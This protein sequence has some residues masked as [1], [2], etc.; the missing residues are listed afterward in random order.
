MASIAIV[1]EHYDAA[2]ERL[3]ALGADVVP[4]ELPAPSED[5]RDGTGT[6]IS[7]EA[8]YHHGN[9]YEAPSNRVDQDVKPRIL[10]GKG[11]SA[12]DFIAMMQLRETNRAKV[13]DAMRGFRGLPHADDCNAAVCQSAEVD[14]SRTPARFTRI[15]NY[16]RFCAMSVPMGQADGAGADRLTNCG[17]R[18]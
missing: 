17:A 1:L 14:Q 8:Y 2:L 7:C 4:F 10:A 11:V 6:I 9:M 18:R 13:L 12:R 16:L 15:V 3:R 5:M